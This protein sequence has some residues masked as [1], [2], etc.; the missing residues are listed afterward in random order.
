MQIDRLIL[1]PTGRCGREVGGL[2]TSQ[3]RQLP[4]KNTLQ[5]PLLSPFKFQVPILRMRMVQL[6]LDLCHS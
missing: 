5:Q 4:R 6:R 2:Q 3:M 1:E